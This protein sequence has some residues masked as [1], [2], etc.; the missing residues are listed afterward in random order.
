MTS[1]PSTQL[2]ACWNQI[3]IAGDRSCPELLTFTHCR[4][5]PVYSVEGRR[6]LERNI[7]DGYVQEW[8]TLLAT[9]TVQ[10]G[11]SAFSARAS[12]HGVAANG[13]VANQAAGVNSQSMVQSIALVVFRI[14]REWLGLPATLFKEVTPASPIHRIPH[15]SNQI[16]LGLVNIRGELQMGVSL[17]HLLNLDS[18]QPAITQSLVPANA[19][20]NPRMMVLERGGDRWVFPV[21]EIYGVQR[22]QMSEL[23]PA[24]A[25]VAKSGNAFTRGLISWHDTHISVL[26]DELLFYTLNRSVL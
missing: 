16:L 1:S 10:A 14:H 7:P 4:N 15:R 12:G 2:K 11:G 22:F 9:A 8:T 23:K 24:P 3:G 17:V 13:A 18:A 25:N 21:E 6:L 19:L 5:C 26:D 20:A